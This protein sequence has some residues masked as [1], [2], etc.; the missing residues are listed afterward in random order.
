[1][2]PGGLQPF[3]LM[4][5]LLM[6]PVALA[7]PDCPTARVVWTSVLG[8]GFWN[9]LVMVLVPFL[10]IGALSALLYRVGLSPREPETGP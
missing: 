8:E 4:V 5:G 7:C 3:A 10:L 6:T 1:M 2:R 9:H